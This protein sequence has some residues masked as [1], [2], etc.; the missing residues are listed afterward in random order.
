VRLFLA[1][2]TADMDIS[3][4]NT[5]ISIVA[6]S[7][8]TPLVTNTE[9]TD[10]TTKTTTKRTGKRLLRYPHQ[11]RSRPLASAA[12][13]KSSARL[14]ALSKDFAVISPVPVALAEAHPA[15]TLQS[16]VKITVVTPI[17][18]TNLLPEQFITLR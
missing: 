6:T 2:D 15:S 5:V 18:N 14:L 17:V 10:T 12:N 7:T 16:T 4:A 3:M 1:A 8:T 9:D 13:P 11:S